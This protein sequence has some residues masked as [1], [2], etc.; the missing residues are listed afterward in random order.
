MDKI[1]ITIL[2]GSFVIFAFG[3]IDY[4]QQRLVKV[5]KERAPLE[6]PA[7]DVPSVTYVGMF[8]GENIRTS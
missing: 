3:V 2:I 6:V 4:N 7:T 1:S 5:E 8:Q